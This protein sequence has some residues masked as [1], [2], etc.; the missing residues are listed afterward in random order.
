VRAKDELDKIGRSDWADWDQSGDL[1]FTMDGGI[2]R[3]SC[4][5]GELVPLENAVNIA[6]FSQL[7]FETCAAPEEARRW[8]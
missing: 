3:L 7:K 8:R 1:L 6:D 2:Y 5:G 4:D